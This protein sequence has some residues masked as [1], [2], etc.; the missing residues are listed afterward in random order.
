[1]EYKIKSG[2]LI[3]LDYTLDLGKD[4]FIPSDLLKEDFAPGYDLKNIKNFY[5]LR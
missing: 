3:A 1:M 2:A 4:I 5:L